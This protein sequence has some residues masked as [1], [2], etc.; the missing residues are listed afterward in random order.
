M[1]GAQVGANR[2]AVGLLA[3]L[4]GSEG[5]VLA[6]ALAVHK[7]S[8]R[9][10]S[11]TARRDAWLVGSAVALLAC[12]AYIIRSALQSRRSPRPWFVHTLVLNLLPVATLL[13]A[14]EGAARLLSRDTPLGL[15]IAGTVLFPRSWEQVRAK[16]GA[17]LKQVPSNIS[18]FV[19]D[20]LLGWTVGPDRRSLDGL[21]LS[22]REGIRSGRPGVAYTDRRARYRIATV[23][24]SYT[25]GLEVPFESSWGYQMEKALGRDFEVLNFGIDGYG[26]DQ[27]YLR[28]A[29]DVRPWR[30]TLV[31]FAFIDHDLYRSLSVY[32]FITFPEWGFPFAKPRFVLR[33]GEPQLLNLPLLGPETLLATPSVERLPF[34]T[35]DPGYDPAEWQWRWYDASRL[36]RFL[37]SRF[38]RWPLANPAREGEQA[39]LNSALLLRFVRQAAAEGAVPLVVYFPSRGDFEGQDRSGK[40]R[41]LAALGRAGVRPLN[42]T[43]CIGAVGEERAFIPGRPHYSAA[44]NLAVARCLSS[45]VEREA[46]RWEASERRR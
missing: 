7:Y 14:G 3:A 31:I 2:P 45:V 30:P 24:D 22:S 19:T 15:S 29:R 10:S 1:S 28:Y 20:S 36:V 32:S 5:A 35:Y 42:L 9:L 11:L 39:R 26:V 40:D 4:Y 43:S 13:L 44:G 17:L 23:G 21:Y 6:L 27:A 8:D 34:V 33:N 12:A 46:R 41:V 38:P 25:F 16:N 18:Y 37:F